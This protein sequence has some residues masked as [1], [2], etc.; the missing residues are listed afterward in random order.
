MGHAE[1]WHSK[2]L[3][4]LSLPIKQN[5]SSLNFTGIYELFVYLCIHTFIKSRKMSDY[6]KCN[7]FWV[8]GRKSGMI[9]LVKDQLIIIYFTLLYSQNEVVILHKSLKSNP[10]WYTNLILKMCISS[11]FN[12]TIFYYSIITH[13]GNCY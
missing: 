8:E 13:L 4:M 9:W 10:I 5:D 6:S 7:L 11:S 3:K 2:N 1:D 12:A